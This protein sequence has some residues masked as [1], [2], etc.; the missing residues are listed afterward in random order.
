M[1]KLLAEFERDQT[2]PLFDG[3]LLLTMLRFALPSALQQSIVSVGSVIVQATINSFGP[4]VIA[5]SAAAAKIINLA[6]ARSDQ[7]Q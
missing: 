4:A 5:G 2:E 6:S 1:P 7:L 3:G